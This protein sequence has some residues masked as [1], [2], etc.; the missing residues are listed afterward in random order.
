MDLS[1][2]AH[3]GEDFQEYTKYQYFFSPSDMSRGIPVPQA[4][5]PIPP[6][7]P[8]VA[9]PKTEPLLSK[10]GKEIFFII[11]Q[12][13]SRRDYLEK[14]L[15]LEQLSLLLWAT[16]GLQQAGYGYTLRT[17]PSAG[18]RHPLE[19]YLLIN[20]LEQLQSGLYRYS[21]SRHA[22]IQLRN[23]PAI[24]DH[25]TEACLGQEMFRTCSVAFIWTAVIQ[26]SRWKYQQR[27]YR[28]IYL[29]AGHVCQNLYLACEALK[30][31]CCAVAAFDDDAV[32]RL[33]EV[34]GKEEFA[35]YLATV[36]AV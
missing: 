30:L 27:A 5:K 1:K 34:D 3:I 8:Q 2:I 31:G 21:P 20:H 16:Q 22:V 23:D 7:V 24:V 12:R 4:E 6:D 11:K 9:L 29:D 14:P 33:L 19:T 18:A 10:F 28:Y 35:I 25:L 17:V 13:R 15:S 32:N 26:R 36:G